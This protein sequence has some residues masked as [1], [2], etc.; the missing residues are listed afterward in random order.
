MT[1]TGNERKNQSHSPVMTRILELRESVLSEWER[2]VRASI[3]QAEGLS[4]P[5][6]V[7]TFPALYDD[8]AAQIAG[9]SP[10]EGSRS[11]VAAEHGGERARLTNYDPEAIIRE[12]Q[13]LRHTVFDIMQHNG[14]QLGSKERL[15][16]DT[17]IDAAICESVMAFSLVFTAIR[18]QF[19]AT[20]A[21]DLRT[22]LAAASMAAELVTH[23]A[24]LETAKAMARK[25][26]DFHGQMDRLI[27]RL[28][29]TMV[30]Q[31]GERLRLELTNF[32]IFELLKDAER[33]FALSFGVRFDFSGTS[34]TGW[35]DREQV[36]RALENL[37][38]NAV[39]YGTPHSEIR[40]RAEEIH[41]RLLLSVH[42]IGEPIPPENVED[43]FH[44][45][46]RALR[47]NDKKKGWGIGLPYVRGV[48]E[49]HGGSVVLKSS[50]EEGTLFLID[51]PVDAR[52][53][54]N[55][56]ITPP[57]AT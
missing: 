15:A 34:I 10:V 19:V 20:L 5:L 54:Q 47:S 32:D 28:L 39:K 21:H 53:F 13:I 26:I 36:R 24:D 43:I 9:T 7:D 3:N 27:Q 22:P 33:Q 17:V 23:I 11:T 52:P 57:G 37:A 48:A 29:D 51:I 25:I 49:S 18:E 50:A 6:L 1:Q 56:K 16:V 38:G 55:A 8:I 42:N 30:F 14:L 41:G 12:Y 40:V 31:S 35:W 45:F 44:I 4:Q 2:R 46:R